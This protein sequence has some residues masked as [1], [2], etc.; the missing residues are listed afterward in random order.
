MTDHPDGLIL[1][2]HIVSDYFHNECWSFL[3]GDGS[4]INPYKCTC[5]IWNYDAKENQ[6]RLKRYTEG[7]GK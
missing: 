3:T 7:G 4:F 1:R 5:G 2:A 6:Y